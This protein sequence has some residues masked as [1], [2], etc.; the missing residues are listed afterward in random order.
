MRYSLN[1][2]AMSDGL[3]ELP[4]EGEIQATKAKIV[5]TVLDMEGQALFAESPG[6]TKSGRGTGM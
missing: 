3:D 2:G 6:Q 4:M 1:T 5:G